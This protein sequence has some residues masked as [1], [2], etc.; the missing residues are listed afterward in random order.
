MVEAVKRQ[1]VLGYLNGMDRLS[2]CTS[3]HP[4]KYR[5]NIEKECFEDTPDADPLIKKFKIIK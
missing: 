2:R 3:L 5:I 1:G 4:E